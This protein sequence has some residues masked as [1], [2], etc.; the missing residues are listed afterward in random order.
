MNEKINE[1]IKSV[2]D[3]KYDA[4]TGI[5]VQVRNTFNKFVDF[6]VHTFPNPTLL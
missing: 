6:F 1:L 4:S 3:L 2:P 5:I